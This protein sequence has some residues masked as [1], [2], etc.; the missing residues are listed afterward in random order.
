MRRY[1]CIKIKRKMNLAREKI[2][3]QLIYNDFKQVGPGDGF[4]VF[5]QHSIWQGK[6]SP[7]HQLSKE[8]LP[9]ICP[10]TRQNT[11]EVVS[12]FH[13]G[14]KTIQH[15]VGQRVVEYFFPEKIIHG[16]ISLQQGSGQ[17]FDVEMI[18]ERIDLNGLVDG[19]FPDPEGRI[20]EMKHE[21]VCIVE[22][23]VREGVRGIK[24]QVLRGVQ[25]QV[26]QRDRDVISKGVETIGLEGI[27]PAEPAAESHRD[28]HRSAGKRQGVTG[29]IGISYLCIKLWRFGQ[30][31]QL[32]GIV[33]R[34]IGCSCI[35]VEMHCD[36]VRIRIDAAACSYHHPVGNSRGIF[37][38]RNAIVYP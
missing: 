12:G 26:F 37:Q 7:A 38:E 36:L 35:G 22:G 5:G 8:H 16:N 6:G 32:I 29:N 3:W 9:V 31:L 15:A 10:I 25:F 30:A 13:T 1:N 18:P 19:L 17:G 33:S 24:S 21:T 27:L 14:G 34:I 28:D 2:A 23:V 11:Y 20:V 4:F